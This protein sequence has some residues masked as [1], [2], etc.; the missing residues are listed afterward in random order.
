MHYDPA[1]LLRFKRRHLLDPSLEKEV[2]H[3]ERARRGNTQ[4]HGVGR[5]SFLSK[6]EMPLVGR[7][8]PRAGRDEQVVGERDGAL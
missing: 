7:A 5:H 8:L 4:K 2:H 6:V 3:G 1:E